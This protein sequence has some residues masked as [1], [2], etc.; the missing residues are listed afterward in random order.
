MGEMKTNLTFK[1]RNPSGLVAALLAI[2][3][4][5]SAADSKPEKLPGPLFDGLGKHHHAVTTIVPK[6]QRY[7]DQGLSLCYAFNH[8]EAIR[9]FRAAALLDPDLAMAHWGIAYASGPHV[10]R[11]MDKEDN[12]RAW[13]AIQ[14]AVALKPKAGEKERAFIDAMAARY[15]TELPTDRA[16]LDK[17][18]A[19]ALRK[20]VKQFPD[21]LDAHTLFAEALMNLMP[22]DYWTKDR[23]PKP[24]IEEAMVALRFVMARNPDHPGANHL[25]IHAVEAGPN[26]EVALPAADRLAFFAPQAGHLVHMPAHIY[27]RVGQY[28][29]ATAANERA[30]RADQSYM[31]HCRAQGFYPGAYYPHNIYFLWWAQLFEGRSAEALRSANK[32]AEYALENYCGPRK[33]LEA[34]R[35]RHLPWLTWSRFG[36]WDEILKVAEPPSTN[37]F[38]VDRVMWHFTRGLAFAARGDAAAA[39]R[40][41]EAMTPLLRSEDAKKLNAPTYPATDTL[42]IA[43]HWLAGKVA[44]A[45]GDHAAAVAHLEKAVAAQDALPY[46][47]PSY[48]PIPA[49]PALGAAFLEGGNA[50]RAE[51]VFREGLQR[52]PRNGWDLF[53]L[54]QSL[55]RQGKTQ[56]ADLVLKE[57]ETAWKRAD[58]KLN[59]GWY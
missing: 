14:S 28:H 47:E 44:L 54:E 13:S 43:E 17:A 16:A 36:K 23:S 18:Y 38:L 49:R 21:D 9:S 58:S 40:E 37:D 46:M 57:L 32:A 4:A 2:A 5:V 11:P 3:S 33:A 34:P 27:M 41:H 6:A 10:N 51:Q 26:P 45:R 31:R 20:V 8:K 25:Y 48:W 55:R 42:A 56:S 29:D 52:W 1:G 30:V 53:G 7:F 12:D 19:D 22:W 15:S 35:L 59:L 24:E 39:A 50:Q